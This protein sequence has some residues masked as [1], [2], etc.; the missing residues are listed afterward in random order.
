MVQTTV[1]LAAALATLAFASPMRPRQDSAYTLSISD[2]SF[3]CSPA[4]C[5]WSFNVSAPSAGSGVPAFGPITCSGSMINNVDYQAC[6]NISDLQ[7]VSAF[8][9]FSNESNV[10]YL[11]QFVSSTPQGG[12]MY[13]GAVVTQDTQYCDTCPTTYSMPVSLISSPCTEGA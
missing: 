1:L 2:W 4:T 6:S 11:K 7:L 9:K 8:V 5:A 13:A 10:L 3:G 12:V